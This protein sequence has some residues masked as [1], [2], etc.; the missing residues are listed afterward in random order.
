MNSNKSLPAH[1]HL[2]IRVLC[3][4]NKTFELFA[5]IWWQ[6]WLKKQVNIFCT[7]NQILIFLRKQP[8]L[9]L[10]K[11]SQ[12]HQGKQ[13]KSLFEKMQKSNNQMFVGW[14]VGKD[15]LEFINNLHVVGGVMLMLTGPDP[16][17]SRCFSFSIDKCCRRKTV[18]P[19]EIRAMDCFTL[20]GFC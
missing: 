9:S 11:Q 3:L 4:F 10:V 15:L 18:W 13:L 6:K 1:K 8:I 17:L 5:V 16:F 7:L 20:F 14:V 19:C 2:I 12:C